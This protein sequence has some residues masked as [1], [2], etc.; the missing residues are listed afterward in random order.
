MGHGVHF[1]IGSQEA[2]HSISAVSIQHLGFP[3]VTQCKENRAQQTSWEPLPDWPGRNTID[4]PIAP[5]LSSS[6]SI[7][8]CF[9]PP[10]PFF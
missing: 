7:K 6:E 5:G 2:S 3:T 4:L 10:S 9:P 1:T 8:S